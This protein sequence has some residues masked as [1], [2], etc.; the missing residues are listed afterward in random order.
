MDAGT[1]MKCKA[2]FRYTIQ[3]RKSRTFETRAPLKTLCF[4]AKSDEHDF[5]SLVQITMDYKCF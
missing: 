1:S 3:Q 4:I 5:D 2:T